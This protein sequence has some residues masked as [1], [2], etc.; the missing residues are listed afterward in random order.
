[1]KSLKF[2]PLYALSVIPFPILYLL[3]D[4]TY[5]VLYYGIKYRRAVVRA[6]LKSS[7][8]D[9]S[10]Q[11]IQ[12]IEKKF[13]RHFCDMSFES[14][15][16]L[17]ISKKTMKKRVR[18]KNKVLVNEL[19]RQKR[20]VLLY[21]AHYGN[22]EWLSFLPVLIP[23]EIK[24]FYRQLSS[25]YFD[26]IMLKL[27]SRLGAECIESNN[28]YKA[29]YKYHRSEQLTMTCLIGDQCPTR[30]S[31]MHWVSFL[32]Q[33]TAFFT[34]PDRIARKFD[35]A[36]LFPS[37]KKI[38]RGYYEVEFVEIEPDPVQSTQ[39]AIVDKYAHVLEHSIR[40][41][42]ELWLWSHRRWK[43]AKPVVATA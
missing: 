25:S 21:T 36:V 43:L 38:K 17:T 39:D 9:K 35:Q 34:G 3:S 20:H 42:P 33:D 10:E 22:W 23:Y 29:M 8:P 26:E 37:M 40:E 41:M 19:F 13:Y 24:T 28:G 14:I 5:G 11:E 6:N 18:I 32:N 31:A 7:F 4:L 15:K 1:M 12:Q 30:K 16:A 27:R 2:L